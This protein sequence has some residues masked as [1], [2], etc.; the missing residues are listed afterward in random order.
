MRQIHLAGVATKLIRSLNFMAGGMPQKYQIE[1]LMNTRL[2]KWLDYHSTCIAKYK[3]WAAV[4]DCT[5]TDYSPNKLR[6]NTGL[7]REY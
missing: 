3:Y 5:P 2:S 6:R 1:N 4:D 7:T